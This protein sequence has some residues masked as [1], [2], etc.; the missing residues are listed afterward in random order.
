MLQSWLY[1]QAVG[2]VDPMI[3]ALHLS[4]GYE[5]YVAKLLM[6]WTVVA[7]D[8]LCER[9]PHAQH[10]HVAASVLQPLPMQPLPTL[11]DRLRF[12]SHFLRILLF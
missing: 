2:V 10:G 1:G 8:V 3:V 5:S 7:S 6:R 9:R 12:Y 11:H 4:R